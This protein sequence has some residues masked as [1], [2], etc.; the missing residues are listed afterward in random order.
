VPIKFDYPFVPVKIPA[1]CLCSLR[2]EESQKIKDL[3]GRLNNGDV[4][5]NLWCGLNLGLNLVYLCACDLLLYYF[6]GGMIFI[7][8]RWWNKQKLW[9]HLVQQLY[10]GCELNL[11]FEYF[12]LIVSPLLFEIWKFGPHWNFP[13]SP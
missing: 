9:I 8:C 12:N 5:T 2:K 6:Y 10:M 11:V 13:T 4:G 7:V 1:W 3:C